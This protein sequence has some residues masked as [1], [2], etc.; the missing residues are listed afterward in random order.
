MQLVADLGGVP[1]KDCRG[2]CKYCYFKKAKP[3]TEPLGC[4]HCPPGKIGCPVC[5]EGVQEMGHEFYPAFQVLNELQMSLMM[6]QV[7]PRDLKINITG[8][9]DVSCYPQLEELIGAINQWQI[10][11]H[12]IFIRCQ[13]SKNLDG[14]Q[15]S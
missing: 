5:N 1:G 7:N 3:L 8:G 9:G 11:I 14:R 15:E 6:N 13:S 4:R 2:F 10:H 12:F